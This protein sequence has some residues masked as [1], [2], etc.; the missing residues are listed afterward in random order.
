MDYLN[1]YRLAMAADFSLTGDTVIWE[2]A[3]AAV[4]IIF[5]ILTACSAQYGQ[6]QALTER[7]LFSGDKYGKIGGISSGTQAQVH[8][9]EE[10]E[11]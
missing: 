11:E 8:L 9:G 2:I 5:R 3:H 1:D 6:A 10:P 7:Q 4:L